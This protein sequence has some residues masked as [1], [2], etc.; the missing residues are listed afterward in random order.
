MDID[1]EG[2]EKALELIGQGIK[3]NMK[4]GN[5]ALMK[6]NNQ[7][8]KKL[9]IKVKEEEEVNRDQESEAE[10]EYENAEPL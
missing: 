4:T 7:F 10:V 8:K 3:S 9:K 5:L 6:I 1:Q 2:A